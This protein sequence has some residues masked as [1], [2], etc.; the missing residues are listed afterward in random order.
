VL[1]QLRSIVDWF[2]VDLDVPVLAECR[3]VLKQATS[4]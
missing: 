2:P 1:K 4:V 3:A